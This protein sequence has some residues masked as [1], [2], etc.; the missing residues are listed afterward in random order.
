MHFVYCWYQR[1]RIYQWD[2][3]P[4]SQNQWQK[5][6]QLSLELPKDTLIEVEKVEELRGEV[7]LDVLP[8]VN[9]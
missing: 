3:V 1:S 4:K 5:L 6:E 9:A 8:A 7:G 2:G